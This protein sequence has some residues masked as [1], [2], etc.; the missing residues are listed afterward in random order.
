MDPLP[1]DAALGEIRAALDV[2]R[3]VVVTAAPGA[4]K[5]TRV[6]PALIDA[7][8]VILL[9][10]RRVAARAIARR[11]A[12]ERGW[13]VGAEIGW[14]IRFERRFD[15][16]TRLLVATEGILTARLQ[17]DPLLSDF[18]TVVLDEFHERS[19]HADLGLALARQAWLARDDLRIVVMS[20]TI[21]ASSVS[22]YLGGCPHVNVPARLHPLAIE[23]APGER[24]ADRAWFEAGRA[25]GC[26]LAFLPGAGDIRRAQDAIASRAAAEGIDVLPLHGSLEGAAQDAALRP[27]GRRRIVLATNIAETTLTVADV[28]TVVDGGLQK[29]ARYDAERGIDRLETERITADAAEQRAGRAARVGPGRAV[30]LWDAADRLR[31][32]RE[33][34]IARVDLAGAV[35]DLLA[36]GTDPR[37]FEWFTAPDPSRLDRALD[38]LQA[39]GA[40]SNGRA[41]PLGRTLQRFPLHPRLARILVE[42]RGAKEAALACAQLGERQAFPPHPAAT[43]CDLLTDEREVAAA[44]PHA[45]RVAHDIG[46]LARAALAD[47]WRP[48]VTGDVLRRALLAGYPDRVCRRREPKSDRVLL[49][50]GA[51][52]TLGR[53]SGVIE[54]EFL[55]ALDVQATSDSQEPRIRVASR[56]EREWL[57]PTN[58]E[59]LHRL[60]ASGVVRAVE[61]DRY[62]AL[63][64]RER[65]VPPDP[66]V[67]GSLLAD[68]LVA[69]GP[70]DET[71]QWLRRASFAGHALSFEDLARRAS[72]GLTRLADVDLTSA[73]PWDVSAAIARDAPGRLAVP[74]GRE[75]PLVYDEH[76]GASASVKLQELFGLAETP[77]LGPHA[78]PVRL[79]LL[80]PNGRP[81]QTTTDLRSFWER[82]Y[83][84]VRKELRGRYPK[85]PWPEDPWTATPTARTTR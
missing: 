75:V 51:G 42:A 20:A 37:T 57:R 4:G 74:S 48:H 25:N 27:S 45:V 66:A 22:A 13:S 26:V 28:V 33:P 58:T 56:V 67:A 21:D 68:A 23:Y 81:V 6:P 76:G 44:L 70:D 85:H 63:V 17:S 64:M 59:V 34:D 24:V 10:P 84:E 35:L 71:L 14:H 77:R 19:L 5:T 11:I 2:H 41:T 32:H 55:V 72:D 36:W 1:V 46:S 82:T 62:G 15:A 29:T 9:Q 30:R 49:S 8:P 38:L 65:V 3:A 43:D 78:V 60:D 16:S 54:A 40:A 52:A 18:R 83:P 7:G 53:E 69:R 50:S 80:A 31:P 39:L 12:E 73:V 47:S 61:R 79:H